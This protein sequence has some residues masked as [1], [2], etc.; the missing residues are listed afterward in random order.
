ME[1]KALCQS[2]CISLNSFVIEGLKNEE[3]NLPKY[4]IPFIVRKCNNNNCN[5]LSTITT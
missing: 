5:L 4:F 1:R 2:I 3:P